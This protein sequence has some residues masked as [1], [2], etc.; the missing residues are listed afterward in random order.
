METNY[1]I[2]RAEKD[3]VRVTTK[4]INNEEDLEILNKG[5][6]LILNI[7]KDTKNFKV[8]GQAVI[9]S[10]LNQIVSE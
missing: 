5:E 1:I 7:D 6:V 4:K 8:K 2:I 3:D 9:V 10:K